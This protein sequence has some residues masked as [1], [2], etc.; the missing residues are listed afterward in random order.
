MK[1]INNCSSNNKNN[2]NKINFYFVRHGTTYS[3]LTKIKGKYPDTPLNDIGKIQ[4]EIAGKVLSNINFDLM[5]CSLLSRTIETLFY[6]RK[7]IL[8]TNKKSINNDNIYPIPF[9]IFWHKQ[10]MV[11]IP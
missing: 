7:S 1:K 3:N 10:S 4:A 6:I 9:I 2:K 8:E 5:C 11:F